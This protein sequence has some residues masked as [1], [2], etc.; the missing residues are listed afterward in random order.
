MIHAY[1]GVVIPSLAAYQLMIDVVDGYQYC[2]IIMG[3]PNS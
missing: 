1:I 3:I 2:I